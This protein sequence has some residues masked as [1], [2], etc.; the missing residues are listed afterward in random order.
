MQ[1]QEGMGLTRR[2]R[3]CGCA[4]KLGPG[5][6]RQLVSRLQV[7]ADPNVLVGFSTSD[8]CGVY[9]LAPDLAIV[10]TVDVMAPVVDDPWVFGQIAA[11]NALSDIYAMGAQPRTALNILALPPGQ[12]DLEIG[13]RVLAGACQKFAEANTALLGGH[14]L[15][16]PELKFGASVTG[17]VHPDRMLTNAG[18]R[19]GDGLVLTKP[20]G[21]GAITLAARGGLASEAHLAA[22]AASMAA[23]NDT[24]SRLAIECGARA[25]TDVTGFGLIGHLAQMLRASGVRATIEAQR[26][27]LLP[28]ALDHACMGLLCR[29]V[30]RTRYH[31][32]DYVKAKEGVA[33]PLLDLLYDPQTSGGLL[34]AAPRPGDLV[35]R[36]HEA[37]VAHAA[38]IGTVH[39]DSAGHILVV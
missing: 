18:A 13:A 6:L 2:A 25:C 12:A 8:D 32:C 4:A 23:L 28:G 20:L 35:T 33:A 22:A 39:E 15:E 19:P 29:G 1:Q 36:L 9:R 26:V 3:A 5:E 38:L 7:P 24:A 11:A 27:P 21:T 10:E 37:G 16:D 30:A 34:I 31:F 14:T 17:T